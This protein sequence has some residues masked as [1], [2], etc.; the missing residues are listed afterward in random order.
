M[1]QNLMQNNNILP[2]KSLQISKSKFAAEKVESLLAD[3]YRYLVYKPEP[4][5]FP[6]HH[7]Y[8]ASKIYDRFI[9]SSQ[10]PISSP[11][12]LEIISNYVYATEEERWSYNEEIERWDEYLKAHS[13]QLISDN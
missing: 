3:G 9:E 2:A 5:M 6:D 8:Q 10:V 4:E 12:G 13:D 11:E 7:V 1:A